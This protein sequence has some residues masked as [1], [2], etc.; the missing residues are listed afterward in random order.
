MG[1]KEF[2]LSKARDIKNKLLDSNGLDEESQECANAMKD[3]KTSLQEMLIKRKIANGLI[4]SGSLKPNSLSSVINPLD[5]RDEADKIIQEL[6]GYSRLES[7]IIDA[8]YGNNSIASSDDVSSTEKIKS[9]SSPR[10]SKK[11][12]IFTPV[13]VD[14]SICFGPRKYL[15]WFRGY[16][17]QVS[18]NPDATWYKVK[19]CN[20]IDYLLRDVGSYQGEDVYK[21]TS[22]VIA[23]SILA[24]AYRFYKQTCRILESNDDQNLFDVLL[25]HV[26]TKYDSSIVKDLTVNCLK[27]YMSVDVCARPCLEVDCNAENILLIDDLNDTHIAVLSIYPESSKRVVVTTKCDNKLYY[28][29]TI[30]LPEFIDH[31]NVNLLI[32]MC[33][34]CLGY[35]G[36]YIASEGF[37]KNIHKNR[38]VKHIINRCAYTFSDIVDL[39]EDIC[40][41]KL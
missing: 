28:R 26:E 8:L 31:F 7:C 33:E 1:N 17:F 40:V 6:V 22:F 24:S 39:I 14:N 9:E 2:V 38:E 41:V 37:Y 35:A 30:L 16:N 23:S 20:R 25:K 15:H 4:Q 27:Q 34:L 3:Y 13:I 29:H 5:G 19:P 10:D 21:Y 12:Y 32:L 11:S 36:V 18:Q